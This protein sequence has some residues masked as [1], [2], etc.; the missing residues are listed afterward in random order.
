MRQVLPYSES[1]V[2][3]HADVRQLGEHADA[4]RDGAAE[5]IGPEVQV[6]VGG[7]RSHGNNIYT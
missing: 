4:V 3:C 2:V 6:P 7:T 5:L 1:A